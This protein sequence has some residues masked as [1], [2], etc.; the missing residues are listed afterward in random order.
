ML[1]ELLGEDHLVVFL[2]H[3]VVE[4]QQWQVRNY[5]R[6]HVLRSYFESVVNSLADAG[7]AVSMDE[8]ATGEALPPRAFA[9]TFDDGFE[10]NLSVAAPVLADE[11]VPATFYVTTNFVE[12]NLM[13]WIDQIELCLETTRVGR[14]KLPW[15]ATPRGIASTTDRIKA[16]DEIRT[17][18]KSDPAVHVDTLV[19]EICEQCDRPVTASTSDPLDQK[20]SW[21]QVRELSNHELF[22][23]GGHS[24]THANLA[25]L[26]RPTLQV[27][28]DTSLELL[29]RK[30]GVGPRHYSYPEG[31]A[32]CYN[33]EVVTELRSRGVICCPTAIEGVNL[34]GEDL[35]ELRRVAVV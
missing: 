28:I 33:R 16:L 18:V 8:V 5:T 2:F 12:H 25:F 14:L 15:E 24:H 20:L 34:P 26:D 13:S 31:L 21:D 30:A 1:V 7:A 9:V 3:G 6:K 29:H 17:H 19:E 10:N 35:F 23:V 22:T 27:E 11:R 4:R 32:H